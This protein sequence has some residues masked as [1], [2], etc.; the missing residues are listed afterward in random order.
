VFA[1]DALSSVAYAPQEIFV[2]L[3][4]A[5]RLLSLQRLARRCVVLMMITV[6]ASYRQNGARLPQRRRRLRRSPPTNLGVNAGI[7]VASALIVDYVL[8]VAVSVAAGVDNLGS[9]IQFV[10]EHKVAV[11]LALIALLTIVN[12]RGLKEAGIAFA[13]DLRLHGRVVGLV[14]VGCPA[15]S[16]SGEVT[17]GRPPPYDVVPQKT[18]L[19]GFALIFLILRRSLLADFGVRP[20]GGARFATPRPKSEE[21]APEDQEDQRESG[22]V[23][24][25]AVRRRSRRWAPAG[26]RRE[27]ACGTTPP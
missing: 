20:K 11:S 3:S 4:L 10:V 13:P 24:S 5:R 7:I 26:P 17:C 9:A 14:T 25:S 16:F 18:H 12:L 6:V 19:A 2:V 1:S 21:N 15:C 23:A 8:T 22:E 27:R